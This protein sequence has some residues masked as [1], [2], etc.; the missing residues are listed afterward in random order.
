MEES[1]KSSQ[2]FYSGEGLAEG[3][4]VF[5]RDPARGGGYR[6][7][8]PRPTIVKYGISSYQIEV[9]FTGSF[10]CQLE[11][12]DLRNECW[13]L[14]QLVSVPYR[15][16]SHNHPDWAPFFRGVA[17]LIKERLINCK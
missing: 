17:Q 7:S 14:E 10:E 11:V 5:L 12:R 16:G 6:A 8:R 13:G 15:K 3:F 1:G 9:N 4:Y 2:G